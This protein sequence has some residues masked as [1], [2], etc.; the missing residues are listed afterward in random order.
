[1]DAEELKELRRKLKELPLWPWHSV[2][3][4][5]AN[6]LDRDIRVDVYSGEEVKSIKALNP[7]A[8]YK[9][10]FHYHGQNNTMA[11]LGIEWMKKNPQAKETLEFLVKAPEVIDALLRELGH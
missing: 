1:M 9:Q 11:A 7:K 2:I 3:G 6:A 10:I 4:K 5:D 8:S